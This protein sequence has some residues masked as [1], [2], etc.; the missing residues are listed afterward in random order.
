MRRR[1]SQIAFVGTLHFVT[2]STRV[3]G[4]WFVDDAACRAV[5]DVFETNRVKFGVVCYGYVLMPD[6]FHALLG[7]TEDGMAVPR[8]MQA[9]KSTVAHICQP[10]GYP[11]SLPLWNSHYDDVPIPGPRA[12]IIRRR[13]MHFNPVKRGMAAAPEDYFW[14]SARFFFFEEPGVITVTY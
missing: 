12:A 13:Y 3:M 11:P 10:H 1:H 2:T 4:N 5:L 7:Q 14:S 6:H 9:F 8:L